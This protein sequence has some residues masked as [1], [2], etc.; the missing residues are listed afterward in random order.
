MELPFRLAISLSSEV[1]KGLNTFFYG[2][3]WHLTLGFRCVRPAHVK[4]DYET[5]P[6]VPS[7]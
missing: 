6:Q 2:R 4:I 1:K 5:D 7:P 3:D